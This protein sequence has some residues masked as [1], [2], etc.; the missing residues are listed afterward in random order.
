MAI[1]SI[2]LSEQLL[3]D[4]D[5]LQKTLG[6][7]GRSDAIR[8]A[9]RTLIAEHKSRSRLSGLIEGVLLVVNPEK[10]NEAVSAIRHKFNDII[11]TELHNHLESGKCL[12]LFVVKGDAER[13]Q[14][15]M[16]LL[17]ASK[18]IEY[19]KLFLS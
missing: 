19:S 17:E 6:F 9:I 5:M 15:I 10:S 4:L 14:K 11:R 12:Y 7:S 8:A 1:I 18:K 16:Q 2:S 3:K 13:I